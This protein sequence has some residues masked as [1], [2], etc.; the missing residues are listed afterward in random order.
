MHAP[1]IWSDLVIRPVS[2]RSG[3]FTIRKVTNKID[4]NWPMKNREKQQNSINRC[5]LKKV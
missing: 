3:K 4:E 2:I 5:F 1:T